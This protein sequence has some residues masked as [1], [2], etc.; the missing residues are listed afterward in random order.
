[1][2][3][4]ETADIPLDDA[5]EIFRSLNLNEAVDSKYFFKLEK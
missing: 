3:Y 1:M 4:E 5:F 2:K